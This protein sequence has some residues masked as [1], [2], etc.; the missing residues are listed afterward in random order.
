M[1]RHVAIVGGGFSGALLAINLLRH[2]GPR[3]V[4][5]ERR[6]HQVARGVAYSAADPG[7]LLNVRAGNMS[8]LPDDPDH[9]VRWLEVR[10]EG[11]RTSFVPR[12]LYGEYLRA[13]LDEACARAPGRLRLVEG[14]AVDL[15]AD[16]NG[17]CATLATG[18]AHYWSRS[19]RAVWHKG[20]TSGNV[21]RVRELRIDC[22]QDAVWLSVEP[23]GPACHTGAASCFYRTIGADGRLSLSAPTA[24]P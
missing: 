24:R 4:L 7:H 20:A 1:I 13:M 2:D 17:V 10:G 15:L 18:E 3:A 16:R 19:R 12:T 6:E 5:V 8:A 9:F 11:G 23:A 22:D 21:Q 14:E